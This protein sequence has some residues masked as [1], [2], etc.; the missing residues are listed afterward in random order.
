MTF[1]IPGSGDGL[2]LFVVQ[3]GNTDPKV[4]IS[5][6]TPEPVSG[7]LMGTGLIAVVALVRSRRKEALN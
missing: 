6:I 4:Q 1:T 2:A 7:L 5:S 3:K